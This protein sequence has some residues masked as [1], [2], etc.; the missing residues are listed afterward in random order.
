M[1][2]H[3]VSGIE[4]LTMTM[5]A[6]RQNYNFNGRVIALDAS[7]SDFEV[8]KPPHSRLTLLASAEVICPTGVR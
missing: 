6:G 5:L 8:E 7:A 1:R 3:D 2:L 4:P